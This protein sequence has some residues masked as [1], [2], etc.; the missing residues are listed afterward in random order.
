MCAALHYEF[1]PI[2]SY[3]FKEKSKEEKLY[4]IIRG[5]ASVSKKGKLIRTLEENQYFGELSLLLNQERTADITAA[6]NLYC[7]TLNKEQFL[8]TIDQTILETLISR[9]SLMDVFTTNINSFYFHSILGNGKFGVVVLVHNTKSLYAIKIVKRESL[10]KQKLLINYFINERKIMLSLNHPLIV[11]LVKTMK[12]DNYLFYLEEFIDGIEFSKYL[13]NRSEE[14]INNLSTARFYIA[15]LVIIIEYLHKRRICHRDLKPE[16]IVIDNKGYLKLLDFGTSIEIE[17]L[18]YTITGT[19]HYIAP[20]VII[21]K[22]YDFSCDYWSIGIIAFE[23]VFDMYPFGD[24][25]N[26]PLQVYKDILSK[27]PAF[28][29]FEGKN[30]PLDM[31]YAVCFIEKLLHKTPIKRLCNT[32]M[33]KKDIFFSKFEFVSYL[34]IYNINIILYC[35]F[36]NDIIDHKIKPDFLPKQNYKKKEVIENQNDKLIDVIDEVS[37]KNYI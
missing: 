26:D 24:G 10:E 34:S 18:T 19:P 21:A 17:A 5:K 20:E 9:I 3:V 12:N 7:Y 4:L 31:Q 32:M 27:K 29:D 33:I 14:E 11:K 6:T 25:A 2:N 36:K 23:T 35:Y 37:K 1:F 15:C 30:I 16:N 13:T 22:G 8:S 28:P